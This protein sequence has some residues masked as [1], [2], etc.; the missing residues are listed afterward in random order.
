MG[1]IQQSLE[2]NNEAKVSPK[3]N[4][5]EMCVLIVSM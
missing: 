3:L 4:K 1:L 5:S 2:T